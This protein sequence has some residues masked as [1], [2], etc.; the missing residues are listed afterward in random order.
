MSWSKAGEVPRAQGIAWEDVDCAPRTPVVIRVLGA[1]TTKLGEWLGK[2]VHTCDVSRLHATD[3]LVSGMRHWSLDVSWEWLFQ[4]KS[5]LP[6]N[7]ATRKW[8][9]KN[10]P[11]SLK[12]TKRRKVSSRYPI[13]SMSSIVMV[14]VLHRND[15]WTFGHV[16]I[17]TPTSETE[18]SC[19]VSSQA[20]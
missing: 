5:K 2:A 9:H 7:L 18:S 12:S 4:K 16:A 8:L 10:T 13:A 15:V 6:T 19:T 1:V 20:E 17:M 14:F 3:W 11:W